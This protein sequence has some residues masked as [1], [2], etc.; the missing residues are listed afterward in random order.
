M[1]NLHD[2]VLE[3]IETQS[4]NPADYETVWEMYDD[5][6]FDT[7]IDMLIDE[8]LYQTRD[9]LVKWVCDGNLE[10]LDRAC[11]EDAEYSHDTNTEAMLLLQQAHMLYLHEVAFNTVFVVYA[12]SKE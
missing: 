5:V 1:S 9:A 12:Y 3:L 10:Y 2:A 4:I 11:D 8:H 6:N 7:H